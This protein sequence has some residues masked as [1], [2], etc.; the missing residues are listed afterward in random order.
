MYAFIRC[1]YPKE[2]YICQVSVLKVSKNAMFTLYISLAQIGSIVPFHLTTATPPFISLCLSWLTALQLLPWDWHPANREES[3]ND[4]FWTG[5]RNG[6]WT[7][8][9]LEPSPGFGCPGVGHGLASLHMAVPRHLA[10]FLDWLL[11]HL[12]QLLQDLH[13]TGLNADQLI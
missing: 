5:S 12:E 11:H 3:S 8:F 9:Q 2:T 4:K 7:L 6:H 1:F 10:Y 13:W